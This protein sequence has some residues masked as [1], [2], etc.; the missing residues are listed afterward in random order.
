MWDMMS[1]SSLP[2]KARVIAHPERKPCTV[3]WFLSSVS[4][5]SCARRESAADDVSGLFRTVP[6]GE[7][8]RKR[9][10]F[11]RS[12]PSILEKLTYVSM[13]KI[14]HISGSSCLR[15]PKTLD[16]PLRKVFPYTWL[17]INPLLSGKRRISSA[18]T[19]PK[20]PA[21]LPLKKRVVKKAW[22]LVKVNISI[23]DNCLFCSFWDIVRQRS[24][25]SF[26]KSGVGFLGKALAWICSSVIAFRYCLR[27]WSVAGLPWL[28]L[29]SHS[30]LRPRL[31]KIALSFPIRKST[32]PKAS[33]VG[34]E[35]WVFESTREG[36]TQC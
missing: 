13:E 28:N 11:L 31:L 16:A 23:E 30:P 35:H 9:K 20:S 4:F 17:K 12:I 29:G 32:V 15:K 34:H 3:T 2:D 14:G 21:R 7:V 36:E 6:L 22:S 24:L 18:F 26:S 33:R 19:C 25:K 27:V 8:G 1:F 5:A 10:P